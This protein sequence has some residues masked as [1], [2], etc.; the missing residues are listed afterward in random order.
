MRQGSFSIRGLP[1]RSKTDKIL[2]LAQRVGGIGVALLVTLVLLGGCPSPEVE[3]PL[4]SSLP[5]DPIA[6]QMDF[7]HGLEDRPIT[8]NDEA[9]H[10]LL[11]FVKGHDES[12]DYDGRVAELKSMHLLS[13][14]FNAPAKDAVQRG[15]VAPVQVRA[16]KIRGGWVMMLT[17]PSPRYATRE[18]MYLN[19][20]PPSSPEQTFSGGEFVGII[21]RAEDYQQGQPGESPA[22]ELGAK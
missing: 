19:L 22:T 13:A 14:G 6:A 2:E 21:G 20:Y 12:T 3:H 16:L 8:C 9:F 18:L 4:T 5:A 7:W 11:L 1:L 10:G 15:T 17:G